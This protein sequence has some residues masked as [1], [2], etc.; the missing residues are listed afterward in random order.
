MIMM[1]YIHKVI[2]VLVV[3]KATPVIRHGTWLASPCTERHS[4][5]VSDIWG[6]SV[7]FVHSVSIMLACPNIVFFFFKNERKNK[8]KL[9]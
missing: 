1:T 5:I 8:M 4:Y 7:P 2:D 6:S 9:K 3:L